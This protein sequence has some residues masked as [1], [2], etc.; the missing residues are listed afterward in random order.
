MK[1]ENRL[2]EENGGVR[3]GVERAGMPSGK[4]GHCPLLTQNLVHLSHG[5]VCG[6]DALGA[7]LTQQS[8]AFV[9]Y[10]RILQADVLGR[11]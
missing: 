9:N 7:A 1:I 3:L 2:R 4:L 11:W 6:I 8:P 10:L 5:T